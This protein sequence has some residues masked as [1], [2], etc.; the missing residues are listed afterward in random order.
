MKLTATGR[1]HCKPY[2]RQTQS[3]RESH[4]RKMLL[5]MLKEE[6]ALVEDRVAMKS[7]QA[8]EHITHIR[9]YAARCAL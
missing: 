2:A 3:P 6:R 5:L 4:Q 1:K 9:D 8:W 7:P